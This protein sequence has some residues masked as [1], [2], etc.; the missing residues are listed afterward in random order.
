MAAQRYGDNGQGLSENHYME[1]V[2]GM[3]ILFCG[4]FKVKNLGMHLV[5]IYEVL[6][7]LSKLGHHIVPL[8]IDIPANGKEIDA[9]EKL[10]LWEHIRNSLRS[11]PI[12]KSLKGEI[13]IFLYFLNEIRIFLLVFALI[14][15]QKGRFDIIYRRHSLFNSEYLLGKVFKIPS[16]KEVNGIVTDEIKVTQRWDDISLRI[17]D[18]IE[19]FN[20]PSA[21]K[22]IVVTSKL[23][24]VL[25]NDYI[26][27]EDKI[28]VIP[29]GANI[30]LF[31]P[32]DAVKARRELN[33]NQRASYVCFVGTL[34]QWQGVEDLIRCVPYILKECPDTRFLIVGDGVMKDELVELAEQ[35]GVSANVI[36]TGSV[37]YE[38]V[39]LYINAGDVCVV[40]K[41]PF[42]GG[43]SPL[44]LCEYMACEKPVVA[45]RTDGFEILEENN[46]GLLVNPE[47][48]QEFAQAVVKLLQD[49]EIRKQMGENGRK[50]VVKNHS[51][52]SVA[53][54][55]AEVC[56]Q[57]IAE[58]K[59][60]S[61]GKRERKP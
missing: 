15:K 42:R 14:V 2:S 38:E 3:N 29:N 21:D 28:V 4:S 40:P 35:I 30:N 46:A 8:K 19:R 36:F 55:V 61:Q 22:I 54:R 23:K 57:V 25:H 44:K 11:S 41:K 45:T 1:K 6:S 56:E 5:H 34:V 18:R 58:H 9:K 52:E 48:S 49:P 53:K 26:I 37:P 31:K 24:E 16:V 33:L 59:A 60:K 43:Y 47:D 51:W 27:P 7:N 32:M 39:P 13:S 50:C 10:S 20:M 17:L 12:Y